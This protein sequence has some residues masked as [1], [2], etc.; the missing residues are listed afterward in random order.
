MNWIHRARVSTYAGRLLLLVLGSSLALL[1]A[2]GL[3]RWVAPQQLIRLRPELWEPVE[4]L[5]WRL[6]PGVKLRVNTGEREVEVL[7]DQLGHRVG[8]LSPPTSEVEFRI[9]ALGDSFLEALQVDYGATFVDR[10][11]RALYTLGASTAITNAGVSKWGPSQYLMQAELEFS[12]RNYDLVLVFLYLGNDIQSEHPEFYSARH[13]LDSSRF[14]FP[15]ELNRPAIQYAVLSPLN[16]MLATRSQLFVLAKSRSRILLSRIGIGANLLPE[17]M[18]RSS[19]NSPRWEA[20][21]EVCRTISELANSKGSQALFVLLPAVYQV[22]PRILASY[23]Q[24][25]QLP[26]E[27]IDARQPARLMF[28]ALDDRGLLV[29]DLSPQFRSFVPFSRYEDL[30]G[31][32]DAHLSPHGHQVVADELVSPVLKLLQVESELEALE[33]QINVVQ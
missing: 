16:R 12:R 5:G 3:V 27:A 14:R 26:E 1:L 7:T 9:L 18:L 15:E 23:A 17:S 25:S 10:L 13:P 22:R 8:G 30:Y 31:T 19:M 21:A 11:Q 2:E 20:T 4:G 33:G 29:L 24:A 32:L 6:R 28:R